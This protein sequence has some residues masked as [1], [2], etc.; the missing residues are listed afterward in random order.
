[1]SRQA[2]AAVRRV[3]ASLAWPVPEFETTAERLLVDRLPLEDVSLFHV[4]P[5]D[6][7]ERNGVVVEAAKTREA[8]L[9]PAAPRATA[10]PVGRRMEST[11]A[12]VPA[13]SFRKPSAEAQTF[14]RQPAA[15]AGGAPG[16]GRMVGDASAAAALD[17]AAQGTAAPPVLARRSGE[18][19]GAKWTERPRVEQPPANQLPDDQPRVERAGMAE[20]RR[21]A[22]LAGELVERSSA[23][24]ETTGLPAAERQSA[25]VAGAPVMAMV[26]EMANAILAAERRAPSG[27]ARFGAEPVT[28]ILV[29]EL[30]MPRPAEPARASVERT[31]LA[32][33]PLDAEQIA[34]LV[35]EALAEQARRH[36]VDLS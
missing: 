1:M 24:P 30:E 31:G 6:G 10:G 12:G 16:M 28:R 19:A 26:E 18:T 27:T 20:S 32:A 5:A 35:N 8:G 21:R 22:A 36:G 25:T 23:I 11:D 7:P 4:L 34:D 9:G 29:P 13:F 2:I 3:L 15:P 17:R 33:V 14:A